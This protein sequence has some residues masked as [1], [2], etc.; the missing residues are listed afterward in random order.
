METNVDVARAFIEIALC[1]SFSDWAKSAGLDETID[2][3][4]FRLGPNFC[5]RLRTGPGTLSS[6][7]ASLACR[8]LV[9]MEVVVGSLVCFQ[10]RCS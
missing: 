6:S 1:W 7:H 2:L 9:A 3:S 4:S 5:I 8:G 10:S